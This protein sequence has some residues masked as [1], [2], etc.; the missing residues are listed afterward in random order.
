[1]RLVPR[2]SS[3]RI[4]V[5]EIPIGLADGMTDDGVIRLVPG[6]SIQ[7]AA[8]G[9]SYS[10]FAY[11]AK[12]S[13]LP[14]PPTLIILGPSLPAWSDDVSAKQI[15]RLFPLL[16]KACDRLLCMLS[17]ERREAVWEMAA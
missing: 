10:L 8:E 17:A 14:S 15:E 2:K 12:P 11:I 6:M 9:P 16:R 1:M 4:T 7:G 13:K 3:T 5:G